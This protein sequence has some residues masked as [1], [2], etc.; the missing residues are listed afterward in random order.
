MCLLLEHPLDLTPC[1][2]HDGFKLHH[3]LR[4]KLFGVIE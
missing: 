1:N 3:L 2:L 4:G